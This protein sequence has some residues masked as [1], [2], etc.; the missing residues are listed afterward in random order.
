M[1]RLGITLPDCLYRGIVGRGGVLTIHEDYFLLTGGIERWL[2]RVARKHAGKQAAGWRFTMRQ[3]SVKSGSSARFSNFALDVR[4]IVAANQLP[5]YELSVHRNAAGDDIVSF[6]HRSRLAFSHPRYDAPR[7]P[8]RKMSPAS[9][10]DEE[11][12]D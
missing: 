5:E 12:D 8:D 11:V 6:L 4:R 7:F 1:V 9:C 2:Y 10:M 3:L